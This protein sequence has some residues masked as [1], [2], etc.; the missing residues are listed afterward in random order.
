MSINPQMVEY[1]PQ[2]YGEGQAVDPPQQKAVNP[3]MMILGL[4]RGRIWLAVILVIVGAVV[5]GP[6][7]Y[8]AVKPAYKSLG[9][10]EV[11]SS[12]PRIMFETE[13]NE[14][15]SNFG[16]FLLTQIE[17]LRSNRVIGLAM[18]DPE[19]RA[20]GRGQDPEAVLLFSD[21]LQVSSPRNSQLIYVTFT[22]ADAKA[23]A[24]AVKAVISAYERV[25]VDMEI[26][27]GTPLM[28]ALNDLQRRQA[29]D[30]KS[31]S[32]RIA[33][34][35]GEFDAASLQQIYDSKLKL[36]LEAEV[37]Y[38][39]ARA[40]S[41]VFGNSSEPDASATASAGDPDATKQA[42]AQ[43]VEQTFASLKGTDPFLKQ[44]ELDKRNL[45][46]DLRESILRLGERHPK[47]AAAKQKVGLI[48]EDI[49]EREKE[50]RA[51]VEAAPAKQ[52]M[53]PGVA[54]APGTDPRII[55]RTWRLTSEQLKGELDALGQRKREVDALRADEQNARNLLEQT[56][57]RILQ[58]SVESGN[59]GGRLSILSYGDVP[60]APEK[61]KRLALTG[62][63]AFGGA[64]LGL[65]IVLLLGFLDRRLLHI[66]STQAQ[67]GPTERLLGVLPQIDGGVVDLAGGSDAAY[68]IHHIRAM[69]QIR[70]SATGHKVL[71]VTSS[72]PGDG[73][74]TLVINV[75]MSLAATGVRTILVDC[76]FDGGGLT[77]RVQRMIA[78]NQSLV[79][80]AGAGAKSVGLVGVLQGAPLDAAIVA[81]H[82]PNLF[83]LPLGATPG[84][85]SGKL[86]PAALRG[87]L[88]ALSMNFQSVILDTGP[89]LGSIE[90]SIIAAES[91]G[92][93]L[94]VSRGGDKSNFR[95]ASDMLARAGASV[96]GV[97][98]NR[99]LGPDLARSIYRSSASIRSVRQD[100]PP[101]VLDAEMVPPSAPGDGDKR[102]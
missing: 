78:K 11:R 15:I 33:A 66:E 10:I 97:V 29:A 100:D 83:L 6:L 62:G 75:G 14:P 5:G 3:L 60:F 44:L 84:T 54:A 90:T 40:Q 4:L 32:D 59:S 27:S 37:E 102:P 98:F 34:L 35:A 92:M 20:L 63:G 80:A 79:T 7:G 12:L 96:E 45:E 28:T 64:A 53:T 71:G 87:V 1:T 93:I 24:V 67:L 47:V 68:C 25:F 43:I 50:L 73:K 82:I 81:T 18:Q 56:R 61:N 17:L 101:E 69:L 41:S 49:A 31:I 13:Q 89:I 77:A 39:R 94:V 16:P 58:L 52:V 46:R 9:V 65:G 36:W 19:W 86:S 51:L 88:A 26:G 55:E 2:Q 57:N 72:S 91:Q 8:I 99:A 42:E 76:D 74:T 22:D 70:Q 21:S 38:K 95:R 48:D 85:G 23:A 30:L